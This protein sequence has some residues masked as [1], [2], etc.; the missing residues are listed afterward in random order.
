MPIPI[1]IWFIAGGAALIAGCS[2][3]DEKKEE[4]EDPPD[5]I[6]K[7]IKPILDKNCVSCH[8]PGQMGGNYDLSVYVR[9]T[10]EGYA[11]VLGGGTDKIPNAIAGDPG[12]RILTM[13]TDVIH[14][15]YLGSEDKAALTHWVVHDRL[16]RFWISGIHPPG[17]LDPKAADF[18]GEVLAKNNWDMAPCRS[19][20]GDAGE[21]GG[22]YGG[23]KVTVGFGDKVQSC[24]QCHG[25]SPEGCTTCHGQGADPAPPRALRWEGSLGAAAHQS[26]LY[27]TT[28]SDPVPCET[29]HTV[30][31]RF[32]SPTHI[33]AD[34]PAEVAF[35]GLATH[36]GFRPVWD[37]MTASC[38]TVYCHQEGRP[39]W[40]KGDGSQKTCTSCHATHGHDVVETTCSVCHG[41]V[42]DAS[43]TIVNPSLHVNGSVQVGREGVDPASVTCSSCHDLEAT[44]PKALSWSG[45]FG[46]A[47]HQSHV[48]G[49]G[50]AAPIACGECH[51]VPSSVFSPNH[52]DTGLPAEVS[53]AT[54][55]RARTGGFSPSWERTRAS[56][57]SV[58]CHQS[59]SPYWIKVDGSQK[60]CT[61]CHPIHGHGVVEGRCTVCHGKVVDAAKTII[62]P[63]LHVN[64][65]VQ[66][67]R[68]GVAPADLTCRSCHDL[69]S[70]PP[71][72][73]NWE[74]SLGSRAHRAHLNTKLTNPLDCGDCHQV[75]ASVLSPGH[76]DSSLPADV[77]F[78]TASRA[79]LTGVSPLWSG[80]DATCIVYCHSPLAGAPSPAWG[81]SAIV[82]GCRSCHGIPPDPLHPQILGVQ[83]C[84]H[85]HGNV[86]DASGAIIHPELHMDGRIQFG[87]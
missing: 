36:D 46:P 83:D 33:D 48:V 15:N 40:T 75:P 13:L 14:R 28:L 1:I 61:S 78:G 84:I 12:S 23:G 68:E 34:R 65:S 82:I 8:R 43:K 3:S 18:H 64:G 72:M 38:S 77:V 20:H 85:C 59:A 25:E 27:E 45:S 4:K 62:A 32:D 24:I 51:E 2:D 79:R 63:G 74:G 80:A 54:G 71:K 5:H 86:T 17:W 60:T 56:C 67:G 21:V 73:L 76:I 31:D 70:D 9:K 81:D 44:P 10:P 11:G 53:F 66:V 47:A 87:P 29:C 26:H 57:L 39:V 58:Y 16:A 22:A 35:G 6:Y 7:S 49:T 41:K 55:S 52:I 69:E 30:P 37:R 42:V 50:I 19:C